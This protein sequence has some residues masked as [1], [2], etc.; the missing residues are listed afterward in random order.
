MMT[1]EEAIKRLSDQLN[2]WEVYDPDNQD[3]REAVEMAMEA[4]KKPWRKKGKW[5]E[6]KRVCPQFHPDCPSF[7]SVFCCTSCLKENDRTEKYC[8]NCGAK[9]GEEK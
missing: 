4:L 5:I 3:L 9:M 1:K 2:T 6:C 8:P 7:Y